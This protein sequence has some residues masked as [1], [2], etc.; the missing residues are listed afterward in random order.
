MVSLAYSGLICYLLPASEL[1]GFLLLAGILAFIF[2]FAIGPGVAIWMVISE[3]LPLRTVAR[4]MAIALFLNSMTSAILATFFLGLAD[5][6]G[7]YGVFW[8]CALF[9]MGYLAMVYF[10]V[11][12]VKDKTL[13]EIEG[14]FANN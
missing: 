2:F 14:E 6:I 7:Y 10:F 5:K 1:K 12:E 3:L 8:L 11:P 9:T 4:G 13:E